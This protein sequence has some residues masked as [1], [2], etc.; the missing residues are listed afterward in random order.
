MD[1]SHLIFVILFDLVSKSQSLPKSLVLTDI[2]LRTD[3]TSPAAGGAFADVWE[4]TFEGRSVALKVLR[5]FN[6]PDG[7]RKVSNA[8]GHRHPI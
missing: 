3:S 1:N 8:S 5:D 4:G 6:N 7:I 2:S